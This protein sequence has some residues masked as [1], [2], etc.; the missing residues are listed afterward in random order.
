VF[1]RSSDKMDTVVG[2]SVNFKGSIKSQSGVHLD[3]LVE[4]DVETTG[5]VIVGEKGQVSANITAQNITISGLVKGNVT[6]KGRLEIAAKGKL[7]GD[8]SAAALVIEEGAVFT[9][10]CA[11]AH[12]AF[13]ASD[14]G[15][16]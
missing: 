2:P 14:K 6:A 11:M 4:G 9:G 12:E 3:G 7:M 13:G 8:I 10:H 1:S 15:G 16:S 5:N